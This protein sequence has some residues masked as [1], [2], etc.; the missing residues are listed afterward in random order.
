MSDETVF[1]HP[2]TEKCRTWLRLSH[3]FEQF[4]FHSPQGEEWHARAAVSTLLD[5]ASVLARADIK[6]ELLKELERYR[7]SLARMADTPGVDTDRL[8]KILQHLQESG[9]GVR[10]VNGQLGQRLRS[11]EFLNSILQRNSIAGGSFDFD[12]PEYHYWLQMP[13][14][15]RTQQLADWRQQ[16]A[17]VDEAVNLLIKLIRNSAVP[18]HETATG[19]F[20]QRSLSS[21][22]SGQLV[23]VS[24]PSNG[25]VYAEIS[26]GKHR[27]SIRFMDCHDWQHPTQ[28]DA[29]VP[30]TLSVCMI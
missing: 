6:S 12:L 29:V 28:V 10:D 15:E 18:E 25:L 23:R 3:L 13:H 7:R 27:F 14:A 8:Q 20:F 21:G 4:D 22:V 16:V 5:I 19:G 9:Q 24:I 1:E 2:L 11:N 30:F 17:V 26:G